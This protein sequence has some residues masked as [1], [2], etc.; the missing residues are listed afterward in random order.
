MSLDGLSPP[1]TECNDNV[2][3]RF[4]TRDDGAR[5][6]YH[7]RDGR[8]PT[9]VFFGGFSSDMTGTKASHLDDWCRDRG[10]A[11]L[12]FDYQGHGASSGRF[13]DGTIGTWRDD[14]L[15]VIEGCTEGPVMM[16]GSSMGAWIMVLV[17]RALSRSIHGLVGLAAAPDFT[18][19]L[20]W[21]RLPE[22]V[23]EQLAS[24]GVIH[25]PSDYDV[26]GCPISHTLVS[27]AR[28]H[29]LLDTRI[30]LDCPVRLVHGLDDTDVPWEMSHRL[31][32]TL[33]CD[34]ATLE[35][36]KG[37]DHRLSEPEDLARLSRAVGELL[38]GE[39]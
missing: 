32:Q 33:I 30:P 21:R 9:V 4:W 20:I 27:E 31:L 11:Y 15:A 25:V 17:A 5:I 34:D 29:L 28:D 24:E 18:E 10:Q 2:E 23:R 35:L 39:R 16:V 6:A 38:D 3:P 7:R 1:G 19:E 26:E 22:D 36:V 14:A 13:V 8:S 37:G 12:R